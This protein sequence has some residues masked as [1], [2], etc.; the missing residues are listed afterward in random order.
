MTHR[1]RPKPKPSRST[2]AYPFS[3][4]DYVRFRLRSLFL[5]LTMR[6]KRTIAQ[7]QVDALLRLIEREQPQSANGC[8]G[9]EGEA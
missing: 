1:K 4:P 5:A 2:F 6:P 3:R 7:R 9:M 8:Y